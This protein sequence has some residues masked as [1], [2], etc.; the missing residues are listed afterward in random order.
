MNNRTPNLL[1]LLQNDSQTAGG[2]YGFLASGAMTVIV[3]IMKLIFPHSQ[4]PDLNPSPFLWFTGIIFLYAVPTVVWRMGIVKTLF[5]NGM[6]VKARIE[7]FKMRRASVI[8]TLIYSFN[9]QIYEKDYHQVN[10]RTS[11]RILEQGEAILLV[12]PNNPNHFLLRDL[13]I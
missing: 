13:Y 8:L 4:S 3:I 5:E 6:E 1:K 7:R 12:D 2:V 9:G 11:L 10:T